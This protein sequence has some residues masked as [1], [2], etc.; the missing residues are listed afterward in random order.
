MRFRSHLSN[1]FALMSNGDLVVLFA[2]ELVL[3]VPN[4]IIVV[5]VV[6][7]VSIDYILHNNWREGYSRR[8]S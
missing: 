3:R 4:C 5:A 6:V 7:V 8:D 2:N 1:P